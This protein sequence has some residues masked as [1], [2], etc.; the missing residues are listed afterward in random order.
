MKLAPSLLSADLTN[1]GQAVDQCVEGGADLLHFDVM[2]GR[3]VPNLTFGV[4]VLRSLSRY[5]SIPVD[6]H[7]MVEEPGRLL[8]LYLEAG[9]NWV[10]VHYE[11]T[12][13]LDRVVQRIK[14]ADARAGVALNPGTPAEVLRDILGELDFVLL[15][16]VN[17]GF[18]GQKFISYVLDKA[19]R[20]QEMCVARK[21]DV[22]IEMDGGVCPENLRQVLDSGVNTCVMGSAVFGADDPV[23]RMKEVRALARG[24]CGRGEF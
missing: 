4:P 7:L 16:S 10:S 21:L 15:M 18:S 17:P 2:D 19:R 12:T 8:D 23:A 9:A 22:D 20:L 3:F 14:S 24:E 5:T 13:H 6:V 11:A 1:L